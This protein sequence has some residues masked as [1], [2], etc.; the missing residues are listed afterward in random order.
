MKGTGIQ[1][2]GKFWSLE[3]LM[4][5]MEARKRWRRKAR[6]CVENMESVIW[7]VVKAV[8]DRRCDYLKKNS[9]LSANEQAP[10]LV[11]KHHVTKGASVTVR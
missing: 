2:H 5:G 6:A 3:V 7:R 4:Q 11:M 10:F 8:E 1:L 9:L